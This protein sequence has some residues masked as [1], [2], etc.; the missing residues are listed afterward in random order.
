MESQTTQPRIA[1]T[2][3][4]QVDKVWSDLLNEFDQSGAP[5]LAGYGINLQK[6]KEGIPRIVDAGLIDAN[7]ADYILDG[8]AHGG[9]PVDPRGA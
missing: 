9:W 6:F 3:S 7:V 4:P 2:E 8:L 5:G 1:P